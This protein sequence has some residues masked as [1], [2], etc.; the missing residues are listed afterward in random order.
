M[1]SSENNLLCGSIISIMLFITALIS[2]AEKIVL[3]YSLLV[4]TAILWIIFRITLKRP[5]LYILINIL[6]GASII[7]LLSFI[8]SFGVLFSIPIIFVAELVFIF[9]LITYLIYRLIKRKSTTPECQISQS[10]N[11]ALPK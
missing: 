6:F 5:L 4:I 3:G 9:D 11:E 1:N 2:T 10:Q 7:C 8:N